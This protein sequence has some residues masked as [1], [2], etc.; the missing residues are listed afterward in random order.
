MKI[1]MHSD[2]K[3]MR[4]WEEKSFHNLTKTC[5]LVRICFLKID[6]LM[7]HKRRGSTSQHWRRSSSRS[8]RHRHRPCHRHW[9]MTCAVISRNGN[10]VDNDIGLRV[11]GRRTQTWTLWSHFSSGTSNI[12]RTT[13]GPTSLRCFPYKTSAAIRA[14]LITGTIAINVVVL[15]HNWH[16]KRH[17]EICILANTTW[18]QN[19]IGM[20]SCLSKIWIW[21]NIQNWA[22]TQIFSLVDRIQFG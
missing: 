4:V 1:Y 6:L 20:V 18:H 22:E 9:R 13:N 5:E 14:G 10:P 3:I 2:S 21:K 11:F 17:D 15:L 12:W 16:H 19:S 8:H 7:P